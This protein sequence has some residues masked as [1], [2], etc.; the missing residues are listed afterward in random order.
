MALVPLFGAM[1]ARALTE[2]KFSALALFLS[3]GIMVPIRLG[4]VRFTMMREA[5]LNDTL[6]ASFVYIAQGLPLSIFIRASSSSRYRGTCA[7]RRVAT[8]A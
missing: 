2:Y 8:G 6:T 4:S 3:I 5:G 7:T 1:A